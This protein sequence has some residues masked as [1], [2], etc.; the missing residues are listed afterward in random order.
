MFWWSL[1]SSAI[2]SVSLWQSAREESENQESSSGLRLLSLLG[3]Y[4]LL[5]DSDRRKTVLGTH[6]DQQS[7]LN[8]FKNGMMVF[9]VF[10]HVAWVVSGGSTSP[11]Q[12][13]K[14][15]V[16][17]VKARIFSFSLSFSFCTQNHHRERQ[18]K[19]QKEELKLWPVL[20]P[21]LFL[22]LSSIVVVVCDTWTY[23]ATNLSRIDRYRITRHCS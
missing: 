23:I 20:I 13:P 10:H 16:I 11:I 3:Y 18:E 14:S 19:E 17:I 7:L 8:N 4:P 21:L 5:V 22:Y 12:P 6:H 9:P 1:R 2:L 15:T